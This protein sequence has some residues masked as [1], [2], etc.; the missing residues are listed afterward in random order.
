MR[1]IHYRT[2]HLKLIDP[3]GGRIMYRDKEISS[4][5]QGEIKPLRKR[6]KLSFKILLDP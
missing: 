2:A 4:L 6:C 1:E 5:S 3:D